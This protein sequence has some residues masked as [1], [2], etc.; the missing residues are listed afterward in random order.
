MSREYIDLSEVDSIRT[1]YKLGDILV[2]NTEQ[3]YYDT[4]LDFLSG[5]KSK[6]L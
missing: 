2:P 5:I 6:M 4:M 3:I 1:L